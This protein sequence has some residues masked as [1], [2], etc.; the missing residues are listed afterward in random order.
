MR[1]L[2]DANVL[3]RSAQPQHPQHEVARDALTQLHANGHEI[4][5]VPQVIYEFWVVATRPTEV[6]GLGLSADQ[7]DAKV[8]T[9]LELYS[10]YQDDELLF[11][12]WRILVN[13]HGVVGKLAHDA[14]LIAAMVRHGI[15]HL[16]TFNEQDFARFREVTV[17]SPA[18]AV[19]FPPSET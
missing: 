19:A 18:A 11:D 16:L 15:T 14:R 4:V 10:L 2:V 7:T 9:N 12:A 1:V 6:N 3:L 13:L 5:I 17:I 8:V